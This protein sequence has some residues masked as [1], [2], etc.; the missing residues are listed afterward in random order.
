MQNS[1]CV[2][3]VSAIDYTINNE[4]SLP[5]G[6]DGAGL[7]LDRLKLMDI[8]CC[9]FFIIFRAPGKSSEKNMLRKTPKRRYFYRTIQLELDE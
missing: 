6:L 8:I 5:Q 9:C 3:H 4:Q 7:S 1:Q 2:L